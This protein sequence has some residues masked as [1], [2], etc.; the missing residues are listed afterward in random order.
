MWF[1]QP[2]IFLIMLAAAFA[3]AFV[4][5]AAAPRGW[6][7]HV[8]HAL[9]L[10]DLAII[11]YVSVPLAVFYALYTLATYGLVEIALRAGARKALAAFAFG[12]G[13]LLCMA[14]LVY[15]RIA[16]WIPSLPTGGI[17]L[18]G[19]AYNMLKAIDA[20]YHVHYAQERIPFLTYANYMLFFPVI[21]AGPVFRYRD[22]ARSWGEPAMLDLDRLTY[23]TKRII[24]GLFSKVVLSALAS[25]ALMSLVV[26]ESCFWTSFLIP[27]AS[28]LVLFFDMAGYAGI[29]IGVGAIMGVAVPENFKKPWRAASFTQFWRYWH[30]TVSD[31]IREHAFVLV[32]GKKLT[33]WHSA[34]L[35]FVVMVAMSLWHAFSP[36]FLLDGAFLGA[37]LALENVLGLTTVK[38]KA[39]KGY[40]YAR[41]FATNYIFALNTMVFTLSTDQMA[42]VLGGFLRL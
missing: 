16:E 39:K 5:R 31:W 2:D 41:R 20:L 17:V 10:L 26:Q 19:M 36:L 8:L 35:S 14:P 37:V 42:Q 38:R 6:T 13:C 40:V 27:I 30:V 22:F 7:M 33:K 3:A 1:L 4:L 28:L 11:G 9:P 21:T 29:A 34:A 12:V 15:T 32:S 23:A 25:W 24:A 18:V